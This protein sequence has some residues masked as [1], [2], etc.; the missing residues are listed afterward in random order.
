MDSRD[1]WD[2]DADARTDRGHAPREFIPIRNIG[3]CAAS[4]RPRGSFLER[5][6]VRSRIS[7]VREAARP[8][9]KPPTPGAEVYGPEP[10]VYPSEAPSN[11]FE[12]AGDRPSNVVGAVLLHEVETSDDDAVLIREAARQCLDSA[13]DEYTGPRVDKELRQ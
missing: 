1:G 11:A 3:Q 2:R 8:E 7:G 6:T 13:R 9:T 12:P 10:A 4:P 5:V